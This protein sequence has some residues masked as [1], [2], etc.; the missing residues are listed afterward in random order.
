[1]RSSETADRNDRADMDA[2]KHHLPQCG[3]VPGDEGS[4][5]KGMGIV[6]VEPFGYEERTSD[7]QVG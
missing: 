2:E 4:A 5:A 6:A 1:M 3:R 7:R